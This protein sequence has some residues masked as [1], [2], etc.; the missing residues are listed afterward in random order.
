MGLFSKISKIES[1]NTINGVLMELIQKTNFQSSDEKFTK[2][3][4]YASVPLVLNDLEAIP[5]FCNDSKL[6]KRIKRLSNSQ[7]LKL[8]LI[9]ILWLIENVKETPFFEENFDLNFDGI[10]NCLAEVF[11]SVSKFKVLM[12]SAKETKGEIGDLLKFYVSN[13]F[14][15]L[16]I[17]EPSSEIGF[18]VYKSEHFNSSWDEMVRSIAGEFKS[19]EN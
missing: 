13:L 9:Q 17:D 10:E 4:L 11:S 15:V 6:K 12:S 5:E 19:D 1:E 2:T 16:G 3:L 8:F 7:I 18:L 14:D